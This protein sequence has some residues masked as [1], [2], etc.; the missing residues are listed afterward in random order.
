[1]GTLCS[2]KGPGMNNMDDGDA[3]GRSILGAGWRL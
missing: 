2:T 3:D 1:V